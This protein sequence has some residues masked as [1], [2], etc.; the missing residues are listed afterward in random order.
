MFSVTDHQKNVN[1][2]HSEVHLPP[3]RLPS[4]HPPTQTRAGKQAE[5][6]EPEARWHADWCSHCV[7]SAE[8][9]Q[10]TTRGTAS[11]PRGSTSGY[12]SEENRNTSRLSEST[13]ML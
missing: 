7:N 8:G 3:V 1:Y 2:N 5:K 13:L 4:V 9:S 11:G 6:R 10:E 12:S